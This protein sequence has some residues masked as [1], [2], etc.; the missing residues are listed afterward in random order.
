MWWKT[1]HKTRWENLKWSVANKIIETV[2]AKKFFNVNNMKDFDRVTSFTKFDVSSVDNICMSADS[3]HATCSPIWRAYQKTLA[4]VD[5]Q[6][7]FRDFSC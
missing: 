3:F 6:I 2:N 1:Q 5:L 7:Y 4:G